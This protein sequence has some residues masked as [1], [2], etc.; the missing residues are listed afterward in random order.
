[1]SHFTKIN[2]QI[3][4]ITALVGACTEMGLKIER[5][6]EA[7]G[8]GSNRRRGEYVIKLNGPYDVAVNR[9]DNGDWRLE[10]DLWRG[11]VE[12]ELGKDFG[13]LKQLYGVHKTSIE[14][15]R[16]GMSVRRRDMQNGSIRLAVCRI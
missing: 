3:R 11:H 5:N 4:D 8:F 6:A 2:T 10:A 13:R 12:N 14:A 9:D 7:R 15:H 1:M 16:R